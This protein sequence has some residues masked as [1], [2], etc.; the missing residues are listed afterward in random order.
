MGHQLSGMLLDQLLAGESIMHVR[1][2]AVPSSRAVDESRVD[3]LVEKRSNQPTLDPDKEQ[4]VFEL[5]DWP[6]EKR[7]R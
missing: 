2:G 1:E 4:I 5:E 6:D 3:E 7:P